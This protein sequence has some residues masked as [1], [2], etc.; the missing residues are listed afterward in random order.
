MS[1]EKDWS[2]ATDEEKQKKARSYI[3][4]TAICLTDGNKYQIYGFDI[5]SPSV[6]IWM[7]SIGDLPHSVLV[8]DGKKWAEIVSQPKQLGKVEYQSP[9]WN[10]PKAGDIVDVFFSH[11]KKWDCDG[12]KY[13]GLKSSKG[14]F[15]C[16]WEK[17]GEV[18]SFSDIRLPQKSEVKSKANELLVHVYE[19]YYNHVGDQHMI[20]KDWLIEKM[21]EIAKWGQQNPDKK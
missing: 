21:I 7:R 9:D 18:N 3:G 13:L 16:E 5:P 17:T 2:K 1:E 19:G 4:E 15:V 10:E 6:K 8:F 20:T 11:I 14:E 12:W